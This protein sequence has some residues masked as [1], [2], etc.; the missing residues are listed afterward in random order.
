M[1]PDPADLLA[2][3]PRRPGDRDAAVAAADR[4]V[5][6][7]AEEVD[8]AY[9]THDS[10]LGPLLL[11]TTARGLVRLAFD[12]EDVDTVL[13]QLSERI[14]PRILAVPS[15]LDATRSEL[16]EYFDRRRRGFDLDV[17]WRF[18]HGFSRRVLRAT[19]RVPYGTLT[20]Y[21]D[22]ARSAGSPRATRAAG[23][24]LGSNWVAIV[25]PCHRV[26]RTGGGLG[27]YGGGLHR[28]EQLLALESR[29]VGQ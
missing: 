3:A 10:P 7:V 15:R 28:K 6:H 20:T 18:A 16:D 5:D 14:S 27:G 29:G 19:A 13:E 24:A 9:T 22:V 11:A 25:V 17:D 23:N 4:L 8:V 26:V 1:T 21:A 12:S 2:R